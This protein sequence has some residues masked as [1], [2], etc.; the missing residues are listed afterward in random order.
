MTQAQDTQTDVTDLFDR[1]E[2][3]EVLSNH[4]PSSY[5]SL[6]DYSGMLIK[7]LCKRVGVGFN[8]VRGHEREL[9]KWL[10][11]HPNIEG[12]KRAP[13]KY[14]D[15]DE[16]ERRRKAKR[17][18]EERKREREEREAKLMK[19]IAELIENSD[20]LS[21]QE[22]HSDRSPEDQRDATWTWLNVDGGELR[23]ELRVRR[24]MC[25]ATV[26]PGWNTDWFSNATDIKFKADDA[27]QILPGVDI[28]HETFLKA[29]EL[30]VSLSAR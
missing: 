30:G 2:V 10:R 20:R 3:A 25:K 16:R 1:D 28:L 6:Q 12:S 13:I 22:V 8:R 27:E 21:Y 9:I 26:E 24:G 15:D 23:L 4:K 18:E 11:E 14:V 19:G 29:A 5:R 7:T 17:A